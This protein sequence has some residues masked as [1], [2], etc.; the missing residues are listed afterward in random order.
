MPKNTGKG[1][2]HFRKSRNISNDVKRQLEFKEPGQEYAKIKKMLGNGRCECY[3]FDGLTRMGHIRGNMHRKVWICVDDIVLVS[4]REY[5]DEKADIIHKY[6]LEESKTL[7]EY[8]EIE[9]SN[10]NCVESTD[11]EYENQNDDLDIDFNDI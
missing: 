3:C 4:L 2:K 10:Q 6:S 11:V 7:Q 8:G 1:G 9:Y 5:Q